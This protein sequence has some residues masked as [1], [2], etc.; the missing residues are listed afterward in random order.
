MKEESAE[1][2]AWKMVIIDSCRKPESAVGPGLYAARQ[3]DQPDGTSQTSAGDRG[4][5]HSK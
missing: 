5:L 3:R 1:M 4:F 2:E